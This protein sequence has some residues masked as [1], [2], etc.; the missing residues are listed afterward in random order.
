[1]HVQHVDLF[2][3]ALYTFDEGLHDKN[4]L[5]SVVNDN[6]ATYML[7]KI[8]S[9]TLV[10]LF[11]HSGTAHIVSGS[12][13]REVLLCSVYHMLS[14][15]KLITL[16]STMCPSALQIPLSSLPQLP[17]QHQQ[18]ENSSHSPSPLMPT[19]LPPVTTLP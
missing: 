3:T 17:L 8:S 2:Y 11:L 16:C 15:F 13:H 14:Y 1:M 9:L 6:S 7:I 4:V 12:M 5:Q 18:K 19:H 10:C